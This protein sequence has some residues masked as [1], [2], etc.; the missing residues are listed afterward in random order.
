MEEYQPNAWLLHFKS[1]PRERLGATLGSW[2]H[3][4]QLAIKEVLLAQTYGPAP[5]S[6]EYPRHMYICC[7]SVLQPNNQVYS[8]TAK[9]TKCVLSVKRVH[10]QVLFF[11]S[12]VFVTLTGTS[13]FIGIDMPSSGIS[14]KCKSFLLSFLFFFFF[15]FPGLY[16]TWQG[17][18]LLSTKSSEEARQ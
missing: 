6:C 5:F 15:S 13:W 14:W 3:N 16:R 9:K 2:A 7:F 11:I 8:T 12:D 1:S 10:L 4:C 17:W 18:I